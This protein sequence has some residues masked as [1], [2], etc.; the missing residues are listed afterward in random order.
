MEN[1]NEIEIDLLDLGRYLLKKAWILVAALVLFAAIGAGF[2]MYGMDEQYTAETRLYILNRSLADSMS[3]SASDFTISDKVLQDYMVLMTGRNVTQ[4]VI[5]TLQLDMTRTQL[6][7]KVSI[8]AINSS[9]V[10]QIV[11]TDTD[12]QRAANIA[13]CICEV[14]ST[15]IKDIMDVDAVNLVYEAEVPTHKSGPSV[16]KNT[17]IAAILGFILAAG[18]FV[19][20][21]LLDDTIRT[22]EDVARHL[23]LSVLGVIPQSTEMANLAKTGRAAGKKP[24]AKQQPRKK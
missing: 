2:T 13:N 15:Q 3:I 18:I 24:A 17:A 6:T 4:K 19:V 21:Y 11:V 10:M 16:T 8:S 12:P 22:E 9:R 7:D 5:D 20:I 1:Q 14:A 23:G